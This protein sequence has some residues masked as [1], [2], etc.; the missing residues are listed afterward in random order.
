MTPLISFAI[1]THNEGEYLR[2][3]LDQ[4][5]PYCQ[6]TGNELV[7]LDDHSDDA[8]TADMIVE[9]LVLAGKVGSKLS[10]RVAYRHLNGDF[11]AHKN[12]LNRMC[13]GKYIFQIDA[14]ET[15]HEDLLNSL[16]ELVTL[17]DTID[18]F[19]IPRVNIVNGLTDDDIK[20]W[21]WQI[22]KLESQ[23]DEKVI[24]TDSDEYKMLKSYGLI[25]EE[26]VL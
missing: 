18:L 5:I 22:S 7:I 6:Q 24:D 20:R 25:I 13:T 12:H 14:D 1:T 10:V 2:K 11:A 21:G 19:L 23:A 3:L 15:L 8:V 4:L 26:T 17:N 9:T 16:E